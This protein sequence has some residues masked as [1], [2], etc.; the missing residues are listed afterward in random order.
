MSKSTAEIIW[1]R[2][3]QKFLDHR[4]SR[5]HLLRFDGGLEIPASSSPDVV[6]LPYSDPTAVD[7]EEML[8]AALSNCHMLWFLSLAAKHG[9]CVDSYI[10]Q[11]SGSMNKNEKGKLFLARARLNP[12][13][14]FSG[15]KNPTAEEFE[16]LHHQAHEECFIASSVLTEIICEPVLQLSV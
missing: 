13:V 3:D 10:D 2:G 9:F 15:E 6:P 12:I 4:Y 11:A 1:Q 16:M 7:P 14:T 5:K 8:V